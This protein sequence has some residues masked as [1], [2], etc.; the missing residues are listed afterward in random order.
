MTLVKKYDRL[1]YQLAE[2]FL[3]SEL[4]NDMRV[5][6]EHAEYL[7]RHIQQAIEDYLQENAISGV[8]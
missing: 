4:S 5:Y 2:H 8:E 6:R 1:C 7:A 3:P